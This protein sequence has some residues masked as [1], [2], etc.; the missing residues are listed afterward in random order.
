[1]R[2]QIIVYVAALIGGGAERV[3]AL[4]ATE[5]AALGH[6]VTLVADFDAPENR[7]FV[8]PEVEYAVL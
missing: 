6:A 4:L 7:V 1:M 5:L 2:R 8:G 3:A